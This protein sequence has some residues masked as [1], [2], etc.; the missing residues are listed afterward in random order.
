M[1]AFL[2]ACRFVERAREKS[3]VGVWGFGAVSR[4]VVLTLALEELGQEIVFYSRPKEGFGNRAGAWIDDFKANTIRRP[5]LKGTGDV[6]DMAGLDVIFVG[7]GVPR[8]EGQSRDDLLAVNTEVIAKTTRQIADLYKGCAEENLP[9]LVYM[10]NPVTAMTWTAYKVSGFPRQK[11]MGQA[12]NLDSRR[13]CQALAG[14]LGLSGNNVNGIVFGDHGD[15]MVASPRFFAV[16][17]VPLS[18][19]IAEQGLSPAKVTEI[20]DYAKKGGTHFVNA[21]G[22][23]ASAGPARAPWKCSGPS[24]AV[25]T[26]F[27][28]WWP[29]WKRNT[30]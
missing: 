11:I 22:Q 30:A 12:G 25:N 19:L 23:S 14:L 7:V 24:F 21:V 15:S 29:W 1:D 5:R 20:I 17:G 10:G 3:K 13:I 8:R 28:P 18:D 2:N 26:T 4:D 6:Q 27:S 9:V 16:N